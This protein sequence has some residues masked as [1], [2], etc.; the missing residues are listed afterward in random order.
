MSDYIYYKAV[1]SNLKDFLLRTNILFKRLNK[2]GF[3]IL[4]MSSET[5]K[6]ITDYGTSNIYKVIQDNNY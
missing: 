1:S 3:V 5:K 6:L 4:N 2:N